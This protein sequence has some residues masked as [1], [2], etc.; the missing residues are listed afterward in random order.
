ME[1]RKLTANTTKNRQTLLAGSQ[2]YHVAKEAV[3]EI[4]CL[5][6]VMIMQAHC[7]CRVIQASY[8]L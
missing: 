3:V 1:E 7:C 4:L 8:L 2:D 5:F 6:C